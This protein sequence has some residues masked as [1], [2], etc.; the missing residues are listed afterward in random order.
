MKPNLFS[1][2]ER[3]A[4]KMKAKKITAVILSAISA[5]S[6][7]GGTGINAAEKF[8]VRGDGTA[9][10]SETAEESEE[11]KKAKED[12]ISS[13]LEFSLDMFKKSFA[14]SKGENMLISPISAVPALTMAA[15]G[16]D[17]ETLKE[18]EAALGGD[19]SIA[20]LNKRLSEYLSS[21]YSGEKSKLNMANSVWIKNI[22]DFGIKLSFLKTNKDYFNAQ[23]FK[24][25]FD[26]STVGKINGWVSDNTDGMIDQVINSIDEDTVMYLINALAFDAEWKEPY[27]EYDIS[28]EDFTD[29]NGEKQ[30]AEMM[31]SAEKVYLSDSKA[32]GFMKPYSGSHYSFAAILPDEGV[33]LE[34]YVGS[35]TAEGLKK[36]LTEYQLGSVD[37]KMPKFE[38]D[39]DIQLDGILKEMG[40]KTAFDVD[41]ANF[42][43]IGKMKNG[44]IYIGSVLQKT[45]IKVDEKGTKAGAAT[46]VSINAT[47]VAVPTIKKQV[48]LDR[49]FIYMI[50]D[51]QSHLP[52]FMGCLTE[53]E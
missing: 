3:S 45:F 28:R 21:L 29:I 33:S 51:N 2:Q 36:M 26:K 17:K 4:E 14:E 11:E 40:I 13:Q 5:I 53:I 16:A 6:F 46:V 52:V 50:V 12:F 19:L 10:T 35:L 25:P 39:Y 27:T 9:K 37:T 44:N 15:N 42:S 47:T 48:Y 34:E 7:T 1:G 18:M 49:P 38:Y 23:I 8:S 20:E 41:K 31:R 32:S 43:K 22:K 30:K 24:E